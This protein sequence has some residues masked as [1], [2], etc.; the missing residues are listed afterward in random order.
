MSVNVEAMGRAAKL[1]SREL[2]KLTRGVKDAAL[3]AQAAAVRKRRDEILAANKKDI[4]T[5]QSQKKSEAFIDRLTLNEKRIEAMAVALEDVAALPD[6]VGEVTGMWRRPNGL[7]VGRMRVPFGV[8]GI[9]YE[10][11]PNVT[12]DAASLC[13]KS[14]NAVILRGGSE[15]IETN[16]VITQILREAGYLAGLPH[17]CIQLIKDTDRAYV[18]Q[19]LKMNQYVD[20]IVP[21]GGESLIRHVMETATVPVVGHLHGVC[22]V[23]VD[24]EADLEMG[25]QIVIN[26]KCQRPG[27]CN[28]M[29]TLLL[30]EDLPEGYI[31]SLLLDLKGKG[32]ELRGCSR[33]I[34]IEGSVKQ[35]EEE[36]WYTE[37]EAL[38]LSVKIVKSMEEAIDHI[39]KYGSHHTDAI[40]TKNFSKARTFLRDVDS[41]CVVV[42]ASTRF[43][44][45]AELG[46]GAEIGISTNKLHAWG[47]MALQEL[48]A[49]KFIV[50]G[51]G[52]IR[53]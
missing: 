35:V 39:N 29:E 11:R 32:V 22:H 19:L 3:R 10:S 8:I 28:A 34:S 38:I 42:N 52:Q 7:E 13:I 47:P 36:D 26:A 25:R 1:A 43:N 45:G 24:D 31:K 51:D 44:D 27:V 12:S 20:L 53:A 17:D 49:A 48:T 2:A 50:F 4:E 9:I 6:P 46:L 23:Y 41:S 18:T 15:S 37:Y 40:V 14:G 30:H 21:R 33:T 16:R 5:A